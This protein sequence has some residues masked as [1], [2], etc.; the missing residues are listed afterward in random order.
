M[1]DLLILLQGT[2][3][4]SAKGPSTRTE[5]MLQMA[6]ESRGGSADLVASTGNMPQRTAWRTM[7]SSPTNSEFIGCSVALR[8]Y[9]CLGNLEK[10]G[11]LFSTNA[12]FP[13]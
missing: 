2:G 11:F 13:S 8:N 7:Q 4:L 6:A 1:V 3:V 10:S 5:S 9:G 12:F